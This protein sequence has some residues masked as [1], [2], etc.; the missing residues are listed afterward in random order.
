MD[1]GYAVP[2]EDL[3]GIPFEVEEDLDLEGAL[4]ETTGG[5]ELGRW[6][7]DLEVASMSNVSASQR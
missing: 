5:R 2:I 1:A 7:A 3:R 4:E 6:V